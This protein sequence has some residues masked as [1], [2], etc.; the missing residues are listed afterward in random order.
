M[1]NDHSIAYQRSEPEEVVFY[2][3]ENIRRKDISFFC[4]IV[5]YL[6]LSLILI[7]SL[8]IKKIY[9]A[10]YVN[11][12]VLAVR[13][14]GE[15]LKIWSP[16][17]EYLS[18]E[19]PG[20]RFR[21]IPFDHNT[22]GPMI[23]KGELQFVITNPGSYVT[24]E[25]EYDAIRIATRISL[26]G[27]TECNKLGAVIFS[28]SG[29]DDI[30]DTGDLK[31]K[32]FA[33]AHTKSLTWWIAIKEMKDHGVN[34]DKD[35]RSIIYTEFP[36]DNIVYSV[37]SGKADAGV[38]WA[39]V[40]EKMAEN[41][42]IDINDFKVL[43]EKKSNEFPL[44][45]SSDLYP[46][47]PLAKMRTTSDFLSRSVASALFRLKKTDPAA[48]AAGISGWTTPLTYQPIHQLMMGL[49]VGP[50]KDY[51]KIT[52][53]NL[54]SQYRYSLL[55]SAAF[56]AIIT[57]MSLAVFRLNRKLKKS[58]LN[59]EYN[60]SLLE[61]R[62]AER[63]EKLA[64]LNRSLLDEIT[65]KSEANDKLNN[66]LQELSAMNEEYEASNE[67]L[68]LSEEELMESEQKYRTLIDHAGE[69]ILV[70]QDN[71]IKFSG[72]NSVLTTGYTPDEL[73]GMKYSDIIHPGDRERLR[74]YYMMRLEGKEAPELYTFRVICKDGTESI[75]ERHA[76]MIEWE[77]RP[78]VLTFDSDIG[79]R[80]KAEN[81]IIQEKER[82]RI[83]LD[84][85]IKARTLSEKE[86]FNF[87]LDS[88]VELT[89]STIGFCHHVADNGKTIVLTTWNSEAL[90]TCD[91]LYG[92]HYPI[93]EAGNWVDCIRE[94]RAVIYND[95]PG[96]PNQ[97]GL[98]EGHTPV[99]RF[100]SIPVIDNDIVRII[101]GV[102]NKSVEYT[103]MDAVSLQIVANEFGKILSI[104]DIEAALKESREKYRMMVEN[105]ND[106]VCEINSHGIFTYLSPS[107]EKILGY[108][109]E[110]LLFTKA[111][112]LI[113]PDDLVKAKSRYAALMK[114]EIPSL[115]IWR[116]RH[117]DG[118]WL[119][120]ECAGNIV[121]KNNDEIFIVGISRD[122]TD[123][124]TIEGKLNSYRD[125]LEEMVLER[126]RELEHSKHRNEM[127]LNSVGEGIYGINREGNITF[128]N[129][130]AAQMLGWELDDLIGKH[131]HDLLH[132]TRMDGSPYPENECPIYSACIYNMK[133]HVL[134]DI[135]WRK[136]GTGIPV[137][138]V[139]TPVAVDG[140]VIGAVVVFRDIT[141]RKEYEKKL[142]EAKETA[143]AANSAKSRFLSSMSHEIRTP[144]NAILGFSQL[145]MHDPDIT[146]KQAE[147]LGI[148]NRSGEHLLILINDILEL[149]KI[150]AG[151][152]AVSISIFNLYMLLYDIEMMF[153]E[154]TVVK[155]LKY[156]M[157]IDQDVPEYISTDQVKLRQI[158]INLI[159]NAV[160]FTDKGGI[161]VKV[162]HE[163]TP[164]Q[165]YLLVID[166]EDSGIG[167]NENDINRI[168]DV[169]EQTEDGMKAG[170][171]GLGLAISIFNAR[172]LGGDIKVKSKAGEGACF[173]MKIKV[174]PVWQH[175]M[176]S[177]FSGKHVIKV[178]PGLKD[179]RILVADDKTDNRKLLTEILESAGFAVMESVN[180]REA[181]KKYLEWNPDIILMDL[182]MPVMNGYDAIREIREM[183]KGRE[184][185][186]IAVTA[187]AFEEDRAAVLRLGANEYLRKPF[188]ENDIFD[189]LKKFLNMDYIYSD[190]K[191][192]IKLDTNRERDYNIIDD[193]SELTEGT[194][195]SMLEA[196][197][198]LDQDQL[199]EMIKNSGC[200]SLT[201]EKEMISMIKKY[202]FDKL[203]ELL[204]NRDESAYE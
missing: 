28:R 109:V 114:D 72:R 119:W 67:A 65:E 23:E 121:R 59:L 202:Q 10:D 192:E 13:G 185:P 80:K 46:E 38:V 36:H 161:T 35:L 191:Y 62:V 137:E 110:E 9:S 12:G 196:A 29:R 40:L 172:L 138:L 3:H 111:E 148:I 53:K 99:K 201:R 193:V 45:V 159:G 108:A 151:R 188:K 170:G 51:G 41:G 24:I 90:K 58:N 155:N 174:E 104:K 149:S 105:I 169:F 89:G 175:N 162:R 145:M 88:A 18:R 143:E 15:T 123:R 63:T 168:F 117:K 165:S 74:G 31:G 54:F 179:Y 34:P 85:H 1:K 122:V 4:K 166:V 130:A 187:S 132:H 37:L 107:Y 11:I 8:L 134:E 118:Q 195:H 33:T 171:T 113:H 128:I 71:I 160:K 147:R 154:K 94:K 78:A 39:G 204:K 96:S 60:N 127:I 66:A 112:L 84:L 22:I 177:E 6:I 93:D 158:L 139:S 81:I 184:I 164:E 141:E 167:I 200:F 64:L 142:Q 70:I 61:K 26:Y 20:Y 19:I 133:Y 57:I 144:M 79:E 101:F 120:I 203:I 115:D 97:K 183:E 125:S 126:T 157:E 189:L 178:K 182:N 7:S 150:E 30:R 75:I 190:N 68:I 87:V 83:L 50:Y 163:E 140:Y 55:V 44:H 69:T 124:K 153:R 136:D 16:M 92:F 21:I 86:L 156:F 198:N 100:M 56:L 181:I 106:L 82:G 173:T 27:K 42:K 47:W 91:A 197:I 129:P 32:K 199:L 76:T 5:T 180:G 49:R 14:H 2:S 116:F 103:D 52:L 176:L 48:V 146:P 194:R 17:A 131:G 95:F 25:K 98:P 186:I 77:G 102:G 135:F 43:E 152:T 73:T